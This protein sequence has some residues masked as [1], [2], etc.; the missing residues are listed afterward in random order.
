MCDNIPNYGTPIVE[1][2]MSNGELSIE[3]KAHKI[4]RYAEEL[5]CCSAPRGDRSYLYKV[6]E[7]PSEK[8]IEKALK[9]KG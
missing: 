2:I 1:E 7:L 3:E 6:R 5:I 4:Y 9:V 8:E